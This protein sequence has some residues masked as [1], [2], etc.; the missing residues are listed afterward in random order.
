[1][2][3]VPP[4]CTHRLQPL[5]VGFMKSLSV[6][7]DHACSNWLRS[8]PGRIITTFQIS[9]T[10]AD[11]YIQSATMSTALNAFRKWGIWPFDQNNLTDS[12]VFS[13]IND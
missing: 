12:D 2:L 8:Q 4:H 9:E 7:Y 5:D 6:F 1:M 11:A 13:F 10:F 3:C